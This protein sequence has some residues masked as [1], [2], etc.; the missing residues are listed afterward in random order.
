MTTDEKPWDARM[1]NRLV[2]PLRNTFITPN[3]LTSLRLLFGILSFLFLSTGDY[4]YSNIGALFFVIS[5][6]LD[7]A[8]GELARISSKTSVKGHYYDLVS[9]ALVNILLFLGIG[10][11]LM[12]SDLG[13]YAGI[14]GAIAGLTV[15]AIFHMR[16]E[17]EK[18]V[19]KLKARQPNRGG[20][21]AEDVLYLLPVITFLQLDY[22]FLLLASLGAPAFCIWVGKDY[23]SQKN[24]NP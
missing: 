12:K 24:T 5:N 17:I 23:F 3:Y 8:D 21:E 16:H 9:D 1:A 7:H 6:F 18:R 19:G 15:A 20:V 4:L 13:F 11:G 14:M 22:Y 2:Y 10:I